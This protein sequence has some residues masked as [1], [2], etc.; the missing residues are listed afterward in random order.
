MREILPMIVDFVQGKTKPN[1]TVLHA[2]ETRRAEDVRRALALCDEAV[3][4]A[5]RLKNPKLLADCRQ[6]RYW[7]SIFNDHMTC[8]GKDPADPV[9]AAAQESIRDAFARFP[10][11][12]RSWLAQNP[13][14]QYAMGV[15]NRRITAQQLTW[16]PIVKES[17]KLAPG[18][19]DLLAKYES[20]NVA[21]MRLPSRWSFR[22]DPDNQGAS[23]GYH[24]GIRLDDKWV[25]VQVDADF[26]WEKQGFA[27]YSGQA[28]YTTRWF[29]ILPPLRPKKHLYLFIS[30]IRGEADVYVNAKK[31]RTVNREVASKPLLLDIRPYL[32]V[33]QKGLCV[34]VNVR[35]A[36][37]TRG[38]VGPVFAIGCDSPAT[39]DDLVPFVNLLP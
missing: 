13:M 16:L 22:T 11:V 15:I 10:R 39:V 2:F 28:W 25:P 31:A 14:S 9:V 36:G 24:K 19:R 35:G 37:N 7:I 29:S 3:A 12:W 8:V 23:A 34:A 5:E 1:T 17:A 6:V 4:R 21:V 18:V 30:S 26:G 32:P 38:I 27:D 20:G 33:G